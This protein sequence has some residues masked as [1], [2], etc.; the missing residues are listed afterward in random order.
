MCLRGSGIQKLSIFLLDLDIVEFICSS[1]MLVPLHGCGTLHL[2]DAV[3]TIITTELV[4][5]GSY[6]CI[7]LD[8]LKPVP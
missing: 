7:Y 1:R 4:G 2:N 8:I 5:N 6:I 3:I